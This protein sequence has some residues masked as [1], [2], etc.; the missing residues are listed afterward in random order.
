MSYWLFVIGYLG[1]KEA[2]ASSYSLF[3]FEFR[4]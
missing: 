3:R 1:E 4:I 2:T